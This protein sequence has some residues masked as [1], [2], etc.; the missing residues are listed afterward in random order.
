[1]HD[2]FDDTEIFRLD[3]PNGRPRIQSAA[4]NARK[5]KLEIHA[6]HIENNGQFEHK[7]LNEQNEFEAAY[8][9]A[10]GRA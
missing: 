8:V 9:K 5:K 1:M 3:D 7:W 6:E 10:M 2:T 4:A